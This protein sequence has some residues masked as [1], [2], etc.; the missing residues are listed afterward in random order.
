MKVCVAEGEGVQVRSP[1][2]VA[3]G[4]MLRDRVAVLGGVTTMDLE[5]VQEAKELVEVK[6]E[7]L[8]VACVRVTVLVGVRVGGDGVNECVVDRVNEV[9][10]GVLVGA[11]GVRVCEGDPVRVR[12][13]LGVLVLVGGLRVSLGV[14]V[15]VPVC[16]SGGGVRVWVRLRLAEAEGV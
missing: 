9:G 15:R 16:V 14:Q 8:R 10:D 11:V 2:G 6:E 13:G 7:Q 5:A 1:L 4:V 3:V 12:G